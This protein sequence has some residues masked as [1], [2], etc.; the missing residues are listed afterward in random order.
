MA[1]TSNSLRKYLTGYT[2]ILLLLS[3]VF[4]SAPVDTSAQKCFAKVYPATR[5]VGIT[6]ANRSGMVTVEV[7]NCLEVQ[8]RAYLQYPAAEI[9]PQIFNGM[10]F[11]NVVKD[12]QGRAEVGN[13]NFT[14]RV[15][16]EAAVD[17]E[18]KVGNLSVSSVRGALVRAKISSDGD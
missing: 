10:I 11:I 8:V 9:V 17:I 18:T 1:C 13:V 6:L 14:I 7:W 16:Y 5:T 4:F 3:V 12:N 15:P 2:T